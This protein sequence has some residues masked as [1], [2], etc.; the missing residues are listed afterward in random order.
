M[1]AGFVPLSA[2]GVG[3]YGC[4]EAGREAVLRVTC[5]KLCQWLSVVTCISN[6]V[7]YH[8]LVLAIINVHVCEAL[9]QFKVTE[10]EEINDNI[11]GFVPT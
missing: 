3:P 4:L 10:F 7:T 9:C 11:V 1:E 8:S 5:K 2:H 6:G